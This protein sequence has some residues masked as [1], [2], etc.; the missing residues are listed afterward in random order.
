MNAFKCL[1]TV[2][3]GAVMV[4]SCQK[5][6]QEKK[7][8]TITVDRAAIT[9]VAA[10]N[11]GVEALVITTDAPYWLLTAPDWVTPDT[12]QG[13]G[14]G[15]STIVSLTIA[16]NYR[17]KRQRLMP[18]VVKSRFPAVTPRYPC[19]SISSDTPQLSTRMPALAAFPTSPNSSIS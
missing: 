9:D 15:Q 1:L 5:K 4:F 19:P 10:N 7:V 14:G 3:L 2:L 11:P 12:K 13:V 8:Y 17:T 6:E 16:S 18:A